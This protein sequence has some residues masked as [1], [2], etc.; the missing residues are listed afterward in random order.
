MA[1]PPPLPPRATQPVPPSPLPLSPLSSPYAVAAATAAPRP[2]IPIEYT[3]PVAPAGSP[4][5]IGLAVTSLV[6]AV[7]SALACAVTAFTWSR[8]Y[9]GS[10]VPPPTPMAAAPMAV[11]PATIPAYSGET[12]RSGGL[13]VADRRPVVNGTPLDGPYAMN[14]RDMLDRLL[15]ECGREVF[16]A[17]DPAPLVPV[18]A[19]DPRGRR[20]VNADPIDRNAMVPFAAAGSP[21]DGYVLLSAD[22]ARF[23]TRSGQTA[24]DRLQV[25]RNLNGVRDVQWSAAAID[26]GLA[27]LQGRLPTLTQPQ[28]SFVA[29]LYARPSPRPPVRPGT[30]ADHGVPITASVDG[31]GTLLVAGPGGPYWVLADGR[32]ATAAR[33]PHGLDPVTAAAVGLGGGTVSF[34]PFMPGSPER[35]R[36]LMIYCGAVVVLADGLLVGAAV[37]LFARRPV[38]VRLLVAFVVVKFVL[39]GTEVG[40]SAAFFRSVEA[41]TGPSPRGSF[42]VAK[43]WSSVA[44]TVV[45][46]LIYP[47]V[48]LILL[49]VSDEL[50]TLRAEGRPAVA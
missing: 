47:I 45:V 32:N 22:R 16:P 19:D 46:Q 35:M 41:Y 44:I 21:S 27:R 49:R 34:H 9:E 37:A 13:S 7:I 50:K 40:L 12:H 24:V 38:A 3:M 11:D 15:A 8:F 28:V 30:P 6:V 48:L 39:I 4:V 2:V 14:R 31:N 18:P 10:R 43:G 36:A 23:Q 25:T 20:R 17:G 5:R 42:D 29:F 26:E 1:E 33:A